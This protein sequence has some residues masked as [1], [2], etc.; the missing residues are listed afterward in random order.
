MKRLI[1]TL[2]LLFVAIPTANSAITVKPMVQLAQVD[3]AATNVVASANQ[4]AVIGN[5]NI[6]GFIQLVN[7]PTLELTSGVESFVSAATADAQGNFYVV[8]ASA[9]PIV[10]T[11]PP[12]SG[13][14][15]P[16]NVVSDPVSSNKSDATNLIYWKVS[17]VGTLLETQSM[18]MAAAVIPNSILVDAS[19]VTV[20]GTIYAN[21]GYKGFV[22][23]WNGAPT[24][25]GKSATQVHAISKIGDSVIAVGQSS[26]KLL[27]TTLKG[28]VD[29]FLA[30]ITA[31]KFISVQRST[32]NNASRAWKSNNSGLVLGGN[33]NTTA[34][35]TKF[36]SN[37]A[38]IWTDRYISTGSAFTSVVGKNIYGAFVSTGAVKALPTWK[39]KGVLVLTFDGKGLITA[40]SYVNASQINAFTANSS[41]GPI[42]LSGGFL[43]RA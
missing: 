27:T 25:I 34:V 11:L 3:A 39:R 29:G 35:I 9:N 7:G 30:K 38:P 40:A 2:A 23:T 8:G 24:I 15:N 26:E 4:V 19:G 33:S 5:R 41:L 37:F 42:V 16:D 36:N 6:N 18:S 14:L 22:T 31:G 10:G 12:I 17:P 43:Y 13:V 32:D 1:A 28:K 21:P 20:G